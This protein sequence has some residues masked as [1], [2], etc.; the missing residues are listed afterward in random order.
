MKEM[1]SGR[2][3][4]GMKETARAKEKERDR[5]KHAVRGKARRQPAA[6]L[7]KGGIGRA[8]EGGRAVGL[9]GCNRLQDGHFR[10]CSSPRNHMVVCNGF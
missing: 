5:V 6:K 8:R 1:P 3:W 10:R 7:G 2:A 9:K 4:D